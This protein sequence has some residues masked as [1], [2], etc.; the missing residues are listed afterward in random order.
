VGDPGPEAREALA[1]EGAARRHAPEAAE[2]LAS[3][4]EKR[5]PRWYPQGSDLGD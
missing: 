4:A 5:P 1:R 3:F 2:G